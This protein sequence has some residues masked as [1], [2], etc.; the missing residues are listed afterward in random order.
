MEVGIYIRQGRRDQHC[1][2]KTGYLRE[3]L[4]TLCWIAAA[5]DGTGVVSQ[6]LQRYELTMRDH[7]SRCKVD[8]HAKHSITFLACLSVVVLHPDVAASRALSDLALGEKQQVESRQ[9][10]Q[11]LVLLLHLMS[12]RSTLAWIKSAAASDPIQHGG[13]RVS[14]APGNHSVASSSTSP[15]LL[16]QGL[17]LPPLMV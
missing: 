16:L 2:S 3:R 9:G 8:K 13:S 6:H 4:Y 11:K 17:S 10:G 12:S 15:Q 1:R 14:P 7:S 5:F